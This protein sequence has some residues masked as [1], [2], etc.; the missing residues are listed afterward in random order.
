MIISFISKKVILMYTNTYKL[1]P[2]TPCQLSSRSGSTQSSY[3]DSLTRQLSSTSCR[4]VRHATS[5]EKSNSVVVCDTQNHIFWTNV[6]PIELH[7]ISLSLY[8]TIL[9]T[10]GERKWLGQVPRLSQVGV[11]SRSPSFDKIS[12]H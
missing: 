3:H 5:S 11:Q 2:R 9:N 1:S 7:A 8:L 4:H 6:N 10:M 12:K